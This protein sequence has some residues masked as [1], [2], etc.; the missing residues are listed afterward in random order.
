M[1]DFAQIKALAEEMAQSSAYSLQ[2]ANL[3]QEISRQV[4]K[5]P[6][7]VLAAVAATMGIRR[8]T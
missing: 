6:I 7:E 3:R 4:E 2:T 1:S 5:A 8:E